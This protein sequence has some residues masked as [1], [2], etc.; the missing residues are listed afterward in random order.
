[1]LGVDRSV[2]R[3]RMAVPLRAQEL[4]GIQI[5]N[6][7]QIISDLVLIL[8]KSIHIIIFQSSSA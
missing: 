6:L 3:A 4:H 8:R 7:L 2:D 1:M 5:I